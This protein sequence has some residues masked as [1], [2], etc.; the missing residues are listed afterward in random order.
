MF[1]PP[2]S[3]R[4]ASNKEMQSQRGDTHIH[5]NITTPD[6]QSFRKSQRQLFSDAHLA[7]EAHRARSGG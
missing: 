1:I 2:T 6:V 5:F 4:I 7:A 3:G